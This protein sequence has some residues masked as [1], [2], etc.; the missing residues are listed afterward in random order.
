MNMS[1]EF[2]PSSNPTPEQE[3]PVDQYEYD[4]E[5]EDLEEALSHIWDIA[6]ENHLDPFPTHFDV[7]PANIM[8]QIG[9]YNGLQ[10]SFSHWTRGRQYRQMKT[11]YDWGLSKIYELV[12]NSNPAQ[13]FLL[14]NNPPIENKFVMAHVLGHTDFFKNN[15]LFAGTRRDMP[16]AAAR[17]AERIRGYEE[18]EGRLEVERFFDATLAIE[19]HIDPY[20]PHRPSREA[21]FK[22]WRDQAE[23][24]RKSQFRVVDEFDDLF[25]SGVKLPE[26]QSRPKATIHVPPQPDRDL[27]GFIR[28]H[29]PHLEEWQRDVVDVVRNES[30][31]FY[32]Q[33]R[34]KIMNEGWA[35]YWHKRIM[36][37]MGDRDFISDKDN[38][39][40][41]KVHSGVVAESQKSLN[42]YYLGMKIY[43]YIEDY[44]NGNLTDKETAWLQQEG[45]PIYPH[46]EGELKDS[47]ATP[48]LRDTMIHNDD[49][50]FIRN[51]FNKIVA[52]RMNMFVYEKREIY[53][54]STQH[55]V[56]STGWKDIRDHLVA[57]MD[58]SGT[59]RIV[60]V[61][62]DYNNS[63]E[64]YLRH[65][66]EGQT[67]DPDYI[68]KT[69]PYIFT[70]WQRPLHL[71]TIDGKLNKKIIYTHDGVKVS[72][73]AV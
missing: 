72:K 69:L 13:A 73:Q 38:E 55:V 17:N 30:V 51:H 18:V 16:E 21:E 68:Q 64:L 41:W 36:R 29:A 32:P 15:V 2:Y 63:N 66:F 43:E 47:P 37:E 57:S 39:A 6:A 27:L 14:E 48:M 26:D 28:N 71:E 42:P 58:N 8:N 62:G 52:D 24:A 5:D 34:T 60:V 49:Q 9:A 7:V 1:N 22:I 4:S 11:T 35:A 44:Y 19:E 59:P 10:G 53:D 54:G 33:R 31:Y 61:D 20:L 56:K 46:F 12:I 65:E 23:H 40:W 25:N 45:T 67:L 70:L 3:K 50:S